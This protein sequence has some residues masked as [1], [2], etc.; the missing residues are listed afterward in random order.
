MS[1]HHHIRRRRVDPTEIRDRPPVDVPLHRVHLFERKGE[2]SVLRIG[3]EDG[4]L[5]DIYHRALTIGWLSFLCWGVGLYLTANVIF[6][7]LFMLDPSGVANTHAGD[8]A[9]FFFFS[10]QTLATIGYG[11]MAPTSHYTNIMVSIEALLGMMFNALSTGLVFARFSRP[12][13]RVLFSNVA[14]IARQDDKMTFSVRLANRRRSQILAA[15]VEATLVHV[16]PTSEG[17][18]VRRY[19]TLKL[20]RQHSPI[21]ALTFLA[22]HVLDETSPLFG[23]TPASMEAE[24]AEIIITVTGLDNITSQTVHASAAYGPENIVWNQR[25]TD[26]IRYTNDGYRVIDYRYF[27]TT[28]PGEQPLP[29]VI[30]EVPTAE[31]DTP[32]Q[33]PQPVA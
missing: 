15:D 20:V 23:A 2:E 33:Q 22:E 8:F 16:V 25:F 29:E 31:E 4:W 21:F 1:Y 24:E 14:V 3:L 9:D 11:L 32:A 27:H 5:G 6:A 19:D 17:H 30:G 26:I 28:Q 12:N 18:L 7:L 10:V 13:A